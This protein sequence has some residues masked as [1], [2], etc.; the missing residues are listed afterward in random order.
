MKITHRCPL[1]SSSF[2]CPE[3]ITGFLFETYSSKNFSDV[4][5]GP[6]RSM[7]HPSYNLNP[8]LIINTNY[9]NIGTIINYTRILVTHY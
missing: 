7:F 2:K 1:H 9:Q 5:S 8:F 3:I 4:I 6:I